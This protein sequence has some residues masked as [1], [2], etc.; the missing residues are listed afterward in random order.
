MPPIAH[1]PCNES[2]E[3]ALISDCL[4]KI[5]ASAV[6]KEQGGGTIKSLKSF[7]QV[8]NCFS[9]QAFVCSPEWA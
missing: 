5:W 4:G 3:D 2:H 6:S 7:G 1:S 9:F 8:E